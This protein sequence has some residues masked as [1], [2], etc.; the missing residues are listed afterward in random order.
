MIYIVKSIRANPPPWDTKG[1]YLKMQGYQGEDECFEIL[2]EV[3]EDSQSFWI[4]R[5]CNVDQRTNLRGLSKAL[6]HQY[7]TVYP[8]INVAYL[9]R[10]VFVAQPNF[11]L[12]SS[13]LV[14]LWPSR[15]IFPVMPSADILQAATRW[16]LTS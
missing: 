8:D 16:S 10:D 3:I 14:L 13:V 1:A 4:R 7:C 5:L 2:D 6:S 9:E 11:Q 15:I 12:L